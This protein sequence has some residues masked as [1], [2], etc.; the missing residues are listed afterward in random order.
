MSSP[1]QSDAFVS[2][3]IGGISGEW[4]SVKMAEATNDYDMG[5]RDFLRAV[6]PDWCGARRDLNRVMAKLA[7]VGV[8]T[9]PQLMAKVETSA[10]NVDLANAGHSCFKHTTLEE[11]KRRRTFL[12]ALDSMKAPYCRQVGALAPVSSLFD[13]QAGNRTGEDAFVIPLSTQ[14]KLGSSPEMHKSRKTSQRTALWKPPQA[15]SVPSTRSV[16][17]AAVVRSSR[18][19]EIEVDDMILNLDKRSLRFSSK[20]AKPGWRAPDE[21][22]ESAPSVASQ[23]TTMITPGVRNAARRSSSS[24]SLGASTHMERD[25][26]AAFSFHTASGLVQSPRVSAIGEDMSGLEEVDSLDTTLA[27]SGKA[28]LRVQLPSRNTSKTSV[29]FRTTSGTQA[30]DSSS[31]MMDPILDEQVN[32]Y[33]RMVASMTPETSHALW[34]GINR[35]TVGMHGAAFLREQE[36]LDEKRALV[37]RFQGHDAVL[38]ASIVKKAEARALV[39]KEREQWLRQDMNK[40]VTNIKNTLGS[41]Q[42]SRRELNGICKKYESITTGPPRT[43]DFVGDAFRRTGST[44]AGTLS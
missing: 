44:S 28:S 5:L 9:I 32:K 6:C 17:M 21:A 12:N 1:S 43:Y 40:R 37:K 29:T 34:S 11:I 2:K 10:I 33:S 35:K 7:D 27:P 19:P 36:A 26:F 3:S 41:M 13:K 20:R 4:T 15:R 30:V 42:Q 18:R 24:P 38:R 16:D 22:S 8:T 31:G 25:R 39:E 14:R 23:S